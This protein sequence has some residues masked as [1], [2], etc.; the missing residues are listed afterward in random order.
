MLILKTSSRCYG[1]Y[2]YIPYN[3]FTVLNLKGYVIMFFSSKGIMLSADKI[4]E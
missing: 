3:F 4:S 1:C 2:K